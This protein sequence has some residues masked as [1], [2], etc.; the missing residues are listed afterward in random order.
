MRF[1]TSGISIDHLFMCHLVSLTSIDSLELRKYSRIFEKKTLN[2]LTN[3]E[4][5]GLTVVSFDGPPFKLFSLRFSYK[6]M[7]APP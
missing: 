3:E 2:V 1:L 6:S 5:G 7:Q 4:R